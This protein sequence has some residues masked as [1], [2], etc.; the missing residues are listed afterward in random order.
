MTVHVAIPGGESTGCVPPELHIQETRVGS[1]Y[2]N[3]SSIIPI[4]RGRGITLMGNTMGTVLVGMYRAKI[5]D[6]RDPSEAY[7][8][9][10]VVLGLLLGVLGIGTFLWG[11][12]YPWG[13]DAFWVFRE[14]GIVLAAVGL[15]VALL[16]VTF[17][18]PLQP[19]ASVIGGGGLLITA[20]AVIWFVVLYPLSWSVAD[21]PL[22]P[23]LGYTLGV[24]LLGAS[25][26]IVPMVVTPAP[27]DQDPAAVTQPYYSLIETPAGWMWQLHGSDGVILG[28]SSGHFDRSADARADIDRFSVSAPAAGIEVLS[29]SEV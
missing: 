19:A 11:S 17:R 27:A 21:P 24:V 10:F 2:V 20:A 7:G 28:E 9:W 13:T 5:G 1:G 6:P 3:D 22:V 14:A 8:Y 18:L 15:P 16:G 23:I 25:V 26:T 12:T 29:P 4:H